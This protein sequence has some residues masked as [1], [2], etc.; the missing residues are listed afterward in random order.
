[1]NWLMMSSGGKVQ[2]DTVNREQEDARVEEGIRERRR[3]RRA[4]KE[5]ET[6]G[7]KE[8]QL[9]CFWFL[10]ISFLIIQS[11]WDE[12]LTRLCCDPY[13]VCTTQS[14]LTIRPQLASH[15]FYL[16]RNRKYYH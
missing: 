9:R 10:V 13:T 7:T 3:R 14:A 15:S 11:C 12:I 16:N 5:G 6:L 8:A 2:S 4:A 1:M